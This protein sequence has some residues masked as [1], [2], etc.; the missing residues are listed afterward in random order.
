MEEQLF[1]ILI[2]VGL[3]GGFMLSKELLTKQYD[4]FKVITIPEDTIIKSI[5]I[6]LFVLVG[7]ITLV[8]PGN[9]QPIFWG[10][11]LPALALLLTAKILIYKVIREKYPRNIDVIANDESKLKKTLSKCED[12]F[13]KSMVNNQEIVGVVVL[14]IIVLHFFAESIILL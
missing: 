5:L 4:F 7:I 6:S 2:M 9:K 13:E 14:G 10:D 1:F 11:L 8:F 3:L 12:F